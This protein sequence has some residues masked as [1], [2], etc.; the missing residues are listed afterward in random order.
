MDKIIKFILKMNKDIQIQEIDIDVMN[1]VFICGTYSK[2]KYS[3]SL[4]KYIVE[5][6]YKK[7]IVAEFSPT[8]KFKLNGIEVPLSEVVYEIE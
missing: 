7:Y 3:K 8:S 1:G 4:K 2:I 6:G 5:A